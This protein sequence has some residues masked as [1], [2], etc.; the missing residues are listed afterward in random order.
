MQSRAVIGY[1]LLLHFPQNRT[2]REARPSPGPKPHVKLHIYL[3][4]FL[5]TPRIF[6]F[7]SYFCYV[8]VTC[9]ISLLAC[10]VRPIFC[11]LAPH[12]WPI[13]LCWP[14]FSPFD[15]KMVAFAPWAEESA[16]QRKEKTVGSGVGAQYEQRQDFPFCWLSLPTLDIAR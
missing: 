6:Q 16:A 14:Q 5:L 7:H 2:K 10:L 4:N 11:A 8:L 13:F 15:P 3:P 9:S 1:N 12:F